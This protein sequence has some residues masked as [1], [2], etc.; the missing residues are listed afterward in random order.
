MQTA[1]KTKPSLRFPDYTEDWA[2]VRLR[3]F[4][5]PTLRAVPKPTEQFL[6][7][8]V[9]SHCRGTFQRED[10]NPEEISMD[11]LYLV[12]EDDLVVNITFAWEGAIA[13]VGKEDEGGLVSHRFPTYVFR[14]E[15]TDPDFFKNIYMQQRF[16]YFLK[17]ISPGGAG[18]NRVLNKKDFL[19]LAVRLPKKS[20][21]KKIAA[22]LLAVDTNIEQLATKKQLL[23]KYKKGLMQQILEQKVRFKD[24]NGNDFPNWEDVRL[25]DVAVC[26]DHKRVP[27]NQTQRKK[28]RGDIPYWGANNVVDFVSDYIFDED[29]VL[30]AE[31]GGYFDEYQTRPIANFT[32]GKCW[33]NNHVHVL[34]PNEKI[35]SKFLYFSLVHKNILGYVNSGTRSKL[36]KSDMLLIKIRL[37]SK[38]EQFKI[39]ELLTS[40]EKKVE[41][42]DI[43]LGS[44]RTFKKGLLQQMFV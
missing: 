1:N 10:L 6:A 38:P 29:L 23:F 14:E 15:I 33:V 28:M 3:D 9:R 41:I 36:N 32:S 17:V 27:L 26:L 37:P 20:E 5:V 24:D 35:F 16:R 34:R 44:M 13:I 31:D 30:L 12:K 11:T 25:R 43:Q 39:M 42:V 40:I 2:E 22:F 18:R 21:Q 4:L 7:I 8:G 19:K